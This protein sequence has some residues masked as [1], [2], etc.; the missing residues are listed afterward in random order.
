MVGSHLCGSPWS[1]AVGT[2]GGLQ[3]QGLN[4]RSAAQILG[5]HRKMRRSWV[6]GCVVAT[7]RLRTAA[8]KTVSEVQLCF[9]TNQGLGLRGRSC[10]SASLHVSC[11]WCEERSGVRVHRSPACPW[12]KRSPVHKLLIESLIFH[13]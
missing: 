12:A 6:F 9:H 2:P 7:A 4:T 11:I 8:V 3:P 10:S 13:F 1:A 5:Q